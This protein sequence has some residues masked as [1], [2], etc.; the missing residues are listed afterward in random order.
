MM[1]EIPKSLSKVRPEEIN[2][3]V[4]R[5]GMIA[6]LDAISLYEQLAVMAT[7][8]DIRKVLADIAKEEKTHMAEF[9]TMLLRLDREQVQENDKGRKEVEELTGKK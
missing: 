6:E 9:E 1:S 8:A 2:M 7:N 4:L 5:A 3:E